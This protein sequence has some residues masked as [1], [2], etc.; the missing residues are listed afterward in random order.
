[1]GHTV[2]RAFPANHAPPPRSGRT[3]WH[4]RRP[5]LWGSALSVALWGL[6]CLPLVLPRGARA[7][8]PGLILGGRMVVHPGLATELRYDSNVF[9]SN[10]LA[11]SGL[12]ASA[13]I[14]RVLPSIDLSTVSM[15]QGGLG[16][17]NVD[18]RIHAGMDYREYLTTN[19]DIRQHRAIGV[20]LGALLSL[21]PRGALNIEFYD[22]FLRTNQP[23]YSFSPYNIDRHTN[24]FGI[25]ARYSPGGQRLTVSFVYDL[26]YDGFSDIEGENAPKLSVYDLVYNTFT[27]R[28]SW[29]FLPKTALFVEVTESIN[30]YLHPSESGRGGTGS[31]PLRLGAGVMGLITQKLA[32]NVL[33]GYGNGFYSE[34][35][36]PSTAVIQAEVKYKP[37][38][39]ST[40][41]TGYKHDFVNSLIGSYFDLDQVSVS[42]SQLIYRLTV[43]T[44]F[45]WERMAFQGDP[46]KLANAGICKEGEV[47]SCDPQL[48][49]VDNFLVGDIKAEFPIRDWLL[50]SVGYTVQ[51]NLSNGYTR[52]QQPIVPISYTKHEAWLRLAVRY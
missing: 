1:M 46:Q 4:C 47:L 50:P 45:S 20:D 41:S 18:F 34:G 11:G 33:G 23:P 10:G 30:T 17:R 49:R 43:Y 36:S 32:I 38:F 31:Y 22:N 3:G 5:R 26:G 39:L 2:P 35:P 9:F 19:D 29:K 27:L 52:I 28:G 40:I 24:I 37:T 21:F 13:V 12:P 7:E 25:R 8:G 6:L 51:A 16:A 48:D 14:L 15:R 42:F 44:R